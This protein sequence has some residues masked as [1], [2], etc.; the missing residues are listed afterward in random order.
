M[1]SWRPIARTRARAQRRWLQ[2]AGQAWVSMRPPPLR[3]FMIAL[4]STAC[5][6]RGSGGAAIDDGEADVDHF[7]R[8]RGAFDTRQHHFGGALADRG[9]IDANGRQRGKC[10]LRELEVAE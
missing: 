8:V 6:R 1:E 3:G 10:V 4:A 5:Q 2:A 7:P 9:A